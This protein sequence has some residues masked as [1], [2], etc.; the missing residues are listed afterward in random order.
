[1]AALH[2]RA[3]STCKAASS[4]TKRRTR[5]GETIPLGR[6]DKPGRSMALAP[7]TGF[8]ATSASWTRRSVAPISISSAHHHTGPAERLGRT[9]AA[10]AYESSAAAIAASGLLQLA[11]LTRTRRGRRKVQRLCATIRHAPDARVPGG[12]HTRLGR[13]LKHGSYHERKDLGVDESDVG[14]VFLRRGAGQAARRA[15]GVLN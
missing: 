15:G 11:A 2:T 4:C 10:A 6:E 12:R 9:V 14:R 1:M 8:R 13:I 5:A 7:R 3:S